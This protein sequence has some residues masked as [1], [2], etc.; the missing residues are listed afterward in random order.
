MGLFWCLFVAEQ[1]LVGW[2]CS[3]VC[4]WLNSVWWD[5]LPV[6]VCLAGSICVY[7]PIDPSLSPSLLSFSHPPSI[8]QSIYPSLPLFLFVTQSLTLCRRPGFCLL[9]QTALCVCVCVRAC[10]FCVCAL[11]RVYVCL[12]VCMFCV[13][14]RACVC[15]WECVR[16]CIL[17][18]CAR[19]CV[20]VYVRV[21]VHVLCVCFRVCTCVCGV[22]ILYVCAC[23][24]ACICVCVLVLRVSV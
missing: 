15:A 21:C 8:L 5:G 16:L 3:G 24:C 22:H 20:G 19:M 18:V 7:L 17:Y 14:V 6:S 23:V 10:V 1:C 11:S 13:C 12:C 2:A 9:L 4:S